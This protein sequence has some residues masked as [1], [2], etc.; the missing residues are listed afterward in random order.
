MTLA[1]D[2]VSRFKQAAYGNMVLPRPA[3]LPPEARGQEPVVPEGTD[4]AVWSWDSDG[5]FYAIAFAGKSNKPL[6]NYRFR[7]EAERARQINDTANSRRLTLKMKTDRKDERK[8]YQHTYKVGDI[9]YSSWGYDQTRV[10]FFQV[11][12]VRGK[13]IVTRPIAQKD[14]SSERGADYVAAS[15]NSFTGPAER[16]TPSPSGVKIDGHHASPWDGKPKYQT[17]F[18]MG[19]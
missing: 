5:K 14:V 17:P 4:L 8:N 19:H 12:D 7:S 3:Y 15:P 11:T 9:L 18:G 1:H 6:W 13:Q 16:S 2:V 10:Y